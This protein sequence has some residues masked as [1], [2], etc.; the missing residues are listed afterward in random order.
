M[1]NTIFKKMHIK[2]GSTLICINAPKEFIELINSQETLELKKTG[3]ADYVFLFVSSLDEYDK[4]IKSALSKLS[5]TGIL[6]I[7]YPK[8]KGKIKY[9]VNR[10]ILYGHSKKDGIEPCSMVAL[11]E[12]WSM[13]RFREIKE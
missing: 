9:D 13:M 6:W 1:E 5:K 11:D 12:S 8:S 2:E 3:L 4:K 10:D 7:S